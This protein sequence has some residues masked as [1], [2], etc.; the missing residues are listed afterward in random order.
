[1]KYTAGFSPEFLHDLP[2]AAEYHTT[3]GDDKPRC[4]ITVW[5]EDGVTFEVP[6][7][8]RLDEHQCVYASFELPLTDP[9]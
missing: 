6:V 4:H 2:M 9:Q 8:L 5:R 3:L 7:K 1:M